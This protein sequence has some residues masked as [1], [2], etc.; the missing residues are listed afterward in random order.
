MNSPPQFWVGFYLCLV[1]TKATNST[2]LI[3]DIATQLIGSPN[4]SLKVIP[5]FFSY[6][7]S[8]TVMQPWLV[9]VCGVFGWP[10]FE[11]RLG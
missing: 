2:A 5:R 8:R 7:K 6:A 10:E 1:D 11:G 3:R 9:S 4:P